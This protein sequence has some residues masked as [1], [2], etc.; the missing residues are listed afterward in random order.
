[1]QRTGIYVLVGYRH[2]D[3]DLPT[4]YIGQAD[5]I[6]GVDSHDKDKEF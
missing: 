4:L 6:T 5:G 2:A 1:M 3:D